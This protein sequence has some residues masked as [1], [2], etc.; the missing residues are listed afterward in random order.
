MPGRMQRRQ[1]AI[2]TVYLR[3]MDLNGR[4]NTGLLE[5]ERATAPR[6]ELSGRSLQCKQSV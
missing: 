2:F 5:K 6:Q 1:R 3:V 4:M